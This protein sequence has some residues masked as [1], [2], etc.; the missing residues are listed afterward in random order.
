MHLQ[1]RSPGGMVKYLL[2][3]LQ[4]FLER[5]GVLEVVLNRPGEVW[6]EDAAGWSRHEVPEAGYAQTWAL[7]R[8][9]GS[10]C[11]QDIDE[12]HPLLSA[13]LPGGERA[14][15]V[16]PPACPRGSVAVTIRKPATVVPR[17]DDLEAGG[18]FSRVVE[19][20][21]ELQPFQHELLELKRQ[22]RFAEFL[23]RAVQLRQ[24]I[25]IS[26]QTGSGKTHILKALAEELHRLTRILTIESV[27]ELLLPNHPLAAHLFYSDTGQGLAHVTPEQLLEC[28]LRM[29]PDVILLAEVRGK[30]CYF[31]IRAAA[32]GHPGSMTTLHAG[33]CA[34]AFEQM[35]LMIRQ[36]AGGTG[37]DFAEIRRLL[38]LTVDVV[39]QF[40]ND[41]TGRHIREVHYDPARKLAMALAGER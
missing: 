26:G 33:S 28:S 32:T 2:R 1:P 8:A 16:I 12:A 35:T 34:E 38:T 27:P 6:V 3:P 17:L 21:T 11:S 25:V 30:E 37:L 19:A 22:H 41:G 31:F 29:R 24:T 7:A 4:P 20:S 18:L 14:Q 36:S 40:G 15:F 39:V 23:R 9:V 13:T 10:Y 5:P